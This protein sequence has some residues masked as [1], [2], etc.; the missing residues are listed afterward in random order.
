LAYANS[1]QGPLV[2]DDT[3]GIGQNASIRHLWPPDSLLHPPA[4]TSVSGR[5][6]LNLSFAVNYAISGTQVKG[7]QVTN[8]LIH[9]LA[10]LTLLGLVRRTVQST[11]V[12]RPR[13]NFNGP[14][15]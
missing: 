11:A 8:L 15:N 3:T 10:G 7:Y 4:D 9:I 5:P 6:V 1:L 13:Q 2:F 12:A 14:S